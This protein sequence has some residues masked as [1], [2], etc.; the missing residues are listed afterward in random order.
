M[1]PFRACSHYIQTGQLLTVASGREGPLVCSDQYCTPASAWLLL[2]NWVL[3]NNFLLHL[4]KV[5][6]AG[7][8]KEVWCK[9]C[10]AQG[11]GRVTVLTHGLL[12]TF[13]GSG[14]YFSLLQLC[15]WVAVYVLFTCACVCRKLTLVNIQGG[16]S[17]VGHERRLVPLRTSWGR[18]GKWEEGGG[19]R[20]RSPL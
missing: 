13:I 14:N 11:S 2:V 6:F 17:G 10:G 19:V 3:I 20:V 8:L 18:L 5:E 7:T 15:Q 9:R 16:L 4:R 12:I 1:S